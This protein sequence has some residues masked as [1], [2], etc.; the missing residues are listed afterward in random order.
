MKASAASDDEVQVLSPDTAKVDA[1]TTKPKTPNAGAKDI[2]TDSDD[3]VLVLSPIPEAKQNGVRASGGKSKAKKTPT[4]GG[5]KTPAKGA[6][7][8]PGKMQ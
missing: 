6:R 1:A 8:T 7:Q 3:E 5:K 4:T 2:V